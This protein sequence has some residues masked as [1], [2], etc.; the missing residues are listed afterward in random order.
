MRGQSSK[1]AGAQWRKSVVQPL[2]KNGSAYQS[3]LHSLQR[4]GGGRSKI[5]CGGF[6]YHDHRRRL[7]VCLFRGRSK[8]SQRG[9]DRSRV[10]RAAAGDHSG[11][12]FRRAA[13]RD[14]SLSDLSKVR[15]SHQK[16]KSTLQIG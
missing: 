6:P 7:D 14:K 2:L 16:Y 13:G 8:L 10:R 12:S 15:Q 1:G 5:Q 11:R 4:P 9:T 3:H